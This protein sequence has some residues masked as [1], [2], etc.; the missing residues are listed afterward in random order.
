MPS[1]E[2][3]CDVLRA[4]NELL[5]QV[6][7]RLASPRADV[8]EDDRLTEGGRLPQPDVA[9]DDAAVDLVAEMGFDLFGHLAGEVHPLVVHGESDAFD[10]ER[11][12]EDVADALDGVQQL[13]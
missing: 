13:R 12:V 10:L 9:G 11:G 2:Y 6:D 5:G 3:S 8:V 4:L 7:V 1:F